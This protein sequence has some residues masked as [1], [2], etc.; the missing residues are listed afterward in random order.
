MDNLTRIVSLTPNAAHKHFDKCQEHA[1]APAARLT[2]EKVRTWLKGATRAQLETFAAR[3][4]LEMY[5]DNQDGTT[6]EYNPDK[7]WNA[8]TLDGIYSALVPILNP[9]TVGARL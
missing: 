1:D 9:E 8:D 5:A 2:Q 7:S 6:W 3:V 4:F